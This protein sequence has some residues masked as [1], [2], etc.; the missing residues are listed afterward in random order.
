MFFIASF[1]SGFSISGKELVPIL[2]HLDPKAPKTFIKSV[3]VGKMAVNELS[4]IL[5]LT[6][7]LSLGDFLPESVILEALEAADPEPIR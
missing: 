7:D 5:E 1:L 4:K 6:M 2:G 3:P